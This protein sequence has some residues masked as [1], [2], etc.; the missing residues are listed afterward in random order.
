MPRADRLAARAEPRPEIEDERELRELG[1]L[2]ARDRPEA[3]PACGAARAHADAGHEDEHEK[4]DGEDQE[5]QGE[6]AVAVV[7]D[8]RRDDHPGDPERRPGGLLRQEVPRIVQRV[9]RA[10]TA[11]AVHHREAEERER[12][13]DE[14]E[15]QV[16][17]R[18]PREPH[19]QDL[20]PMT[21]CT[22]ATKRSPVHEAPPESSCASG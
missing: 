20:T 16:V 1:G 17:R 11:R 19:F 22:N 12:G 8:P 6:R 15:R 13:D 7:I 4:R 3:E 21:S 9:E 10:D 5:R 18:R 2:D 14:Q